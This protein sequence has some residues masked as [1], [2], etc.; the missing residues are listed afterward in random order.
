M[1]K[2][3][4]TISTFAL[5]STSAMACE[6]CTPTFHSEY[7]GTTSEPTDTHKNDVPQATTLMIGN[8]INAATSHTMMQGSGGNGGGGDATHTDHYVSVPD[9]NCKDDRESYGKST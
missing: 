1:A 7:T 4:L 5:L 9:H 6:Q 2:L 8:W 3:F